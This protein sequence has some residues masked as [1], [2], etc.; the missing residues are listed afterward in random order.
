MS[1]LS[2]LHHQGLH[3]R[4]W[5]PFLF[6]TSPASHLPSIKEGERIFPKEFVGLSSCLVLSEA[7]PHPLQTIL[8]VLLS[9]SQAHTLHGSSAHI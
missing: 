9:A 3:R 6:Y 5:L 7:F 1:H 4:C 2:S 8:R